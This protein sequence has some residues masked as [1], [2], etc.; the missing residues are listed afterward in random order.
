MSGV[1][2]VEPESVPTSKA[3]QQPPAE[4][5]EQQADDQEEDGTAGGEEA[6][7]ST[8]GRSEPDAATKT[9][10]AFYMRT[11]TCAYVSAAAAV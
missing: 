7:A 2:G 9:A 6:P 10:C 11:G 5:E 8:S 1:S 3:E 4:E